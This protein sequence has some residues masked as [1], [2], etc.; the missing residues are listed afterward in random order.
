MPNTIKSHL[1]NAMLS[2]DKKR[3]VTLRNILAKLKLKEIEKKEEI[4]KHKLFHKK[5][6][7]Y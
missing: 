3:M 2:K 4:K 7:Y 6:I 5:K 1:K